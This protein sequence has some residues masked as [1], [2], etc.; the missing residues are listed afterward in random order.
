MDSDKIFTGT[1]M[2]C[3]KYEK[4]DGYSIPKSEVYKENAILLKIK[5]YFYVD[6]DELNLLEIAYLHLR[7]EKD[8]HQLSKFMC[9][10][11]HGYCKDELFIKQNTLK[12]YV[13]NEGKKNI[14]LLSLKKENNLKISN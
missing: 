2:K 1:I 7:S 9:E 8:I 6:I 5:D 4:I 10:H 13:P 12:P 3:V 11:H 14:S